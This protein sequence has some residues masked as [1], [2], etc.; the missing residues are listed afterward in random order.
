MAPGDLDTKHNITA[1][2]SNLS[3]SLVITVIEKK[4]IRTRLRDFSYM[5]INIHKVAEKR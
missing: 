1:V 3:V 5:G 4:I 2:V